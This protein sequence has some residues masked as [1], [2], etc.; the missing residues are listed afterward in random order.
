MTIRLRYLLVKYIIALSLFTISI[1]RSKNLVCET[2]SCIELANEL[3]KDMNESIEPCDD[4]Y[5]FTC[6]NWMNSNPLPTGQMLIR[7]YQMASDI[8][9][10]IEDLLSSAP[11]SN[12]TRAFAMTKDLYKKCTD[13][14]GNDKLGISSVLRVL[15][16]FYDW[17]IL[18]AK[19][20]PINKSWQEY[21]KK[22]LIKYLIDSFFSI[23]VMEYTSR[24]NKKKFMAKLS[25]PELVL[26]PELSRPKKNLATIQV[27]KEFIMNVT[28]RI[29]Q[30]KNA[31]V[32]Y[33][34]IQDDVNEIVDLEIKLAKILNNIDYKMT[35]ITLGKFQ[36][37]F[38]KASGGN[39][40][41][42]INWLDI[43]RETFEQ[44]NVN[45]SDTTKIIVYDVHN[46]FLKLPILLNKT[47]TR[48][49]INYIMWRFLEDNVKDTDNIMRSYVVKLNENAL[50]VKDFKPRTTECM[51]I[52]SDLLYYTIGYEYAKKYFTPNAIPMAKE[53]AAN[54][55]NTTT[56]LIQN[57]I[58]MSNNTKKNIIEKIDAIKIYL[59]YPDWFSNETIDNYYASYQTKSTHF[60]SLLSL[61]VF[62]ALKDLK[63]LE[64][65]KDD[66]PM[67][68][69]IAKAIN[70][71]SDT[72]EITYTLVDLELLYNAELPP[73]INYAALGMALAHDI[74]H[75]F[76]EEDNFESAENF[77]DLKT[78]EK[79]K[80]CFVKVFNKYQRREAEL[81]NPIIYNFQIYDSS[82][83]GDHLSQIF[84]LSVSFS[85]YQKY[86]KEHGGRDIVLP[87]LEKYKGNQLFFI[88]YGNVSF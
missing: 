26:N 22:M 36:K 30:M 76:D 66:R 54:I 77:N 42:S 3:K 60:E 33:E 10:K 88:H 16:E 40:H 83:I 55:K 51:E 8:Y 78:F 45:I 82:T 81:S 65:T 63:K 38:D 75:A 27:Y 80:N 61:K 72:N 71:D 52:Y 67:F 59:G 48:T 6:N 87:G 85:A 44:V 34:S 15:E 47:N 29:A 25:A 74:Y 4:M 24:N 57:T 84:G 13:I 86:I 7:K 35:K 62:I 64:Q 5:K 69:P 17:P 43:F 46:Y 50:G 41:T 2:K 19:S 68:N 79:K 9:K 70:Y 58:W 56:N 23:G 28:Y 14:E 49:I 1:V 32:S 21:D 39:E 37:L 53:I 31:G 18:K 12:E 20:E 11:S 73:V